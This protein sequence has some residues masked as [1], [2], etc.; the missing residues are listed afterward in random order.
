MKM[1]EPWSTE[2]SDVERKNERN[3]YTASEA[4]LLMD[5][6]LWMTAREYTW[7]NGRDGTT[8]E[9]WAWGPYPECIRTTSRFTEEAAKR[10]SDK[11]KFAKIPE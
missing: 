2:E 9:Y 7:R 1:T 5:L 6:G 11:W 10:I 4:I 8:G 3:E